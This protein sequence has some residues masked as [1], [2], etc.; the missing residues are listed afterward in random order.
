MKFNLAFC[1]FIVTLL[2]Q[3]LLSQSN[4]RI[5][6]SDNDRLVKAL[7]NIKQVAENKETYLSVRVY[8]LD[9]GIG[10]AGNPS[11]EVSHDV[12]VAVSEFDDAPMQN[13]FEIGPFINPK[14]IK[15]VEVN[16]Y[17][18]SFEIEHGN[19]HERKRI[20]FKAHIDEIIQL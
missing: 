9:N 19:F 7:N 6:T 4:F 18:K 2:P 8:I 13:L 16:Q 12:L 15:W 10:S 17:N 3:L 14:F 5:G 1:F 11:S 20:K